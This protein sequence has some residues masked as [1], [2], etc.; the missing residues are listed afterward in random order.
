MAMVPTTRGQI[1]VNLPDRATIFE[2][3][4]TSPSEGWLVGAVFN[5]DFRTTQSSLILRYR[6]DAWQPVDDPLPNAFLDGIAMVSPLEG[7]VTGYNRVTGESYLLHTDGGPWKPVALPFQPTNG[8]YYGGIRML[9][10]DEGWLV[11]NP[12][13]GWKGDYRESLLLHYQRGVW[14]PVTVP[15]PLVW[16]FAP[17][18]PDDLWV[19]GNASTRSAY[20]KDSTLAHY[21]GG[22]WTTGPAPDHTLFHTLRMLSPTDGYAMGWQ[23]RT[24]PWFRNS[25]PPAVVLRYDG[26][27]FHPVDTGADPAAQALELFDDV[28]GW[29]FVKAE[30]PPGSA[31]R[32]N[33][34]I[35]KA[36]R[37]IGPDWHVVD[38]PFTDIIHVSPVVRAVPGEYWAAAQY[39]LLPEI[40]DNFHWEL[41]HFTGGRW[42]E[43]P[44]R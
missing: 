10:P 32:A 26:K 5:P 13:S 4:L 39:A 40:S 18:G 41:L 19:V 34:V 38:W 36:Q 1:T 9:S 11:V 28:D 33:D 31:W 27:A 37:K 30:N 44:P 3:T 17:V 6:D 43:Y 35:T 16:D 22:R 15:V 21:Q 29:A 24:D 2:L 42:H 7:W 8:S 12:A 14:T 20:R 25:D 23:P